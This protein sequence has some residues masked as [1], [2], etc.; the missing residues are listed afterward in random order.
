MAKTQNEIFDLIVEGLSS[1]FQLD[2]A[3]ITPEARLY[4]DLDID[5]IDAV[6][7][8]ARLQ[9]EIGMRLSPEVFKAVRT[10][11]DLVTALDGL[12]NHPVASAPAGGSESGP[13]QPIG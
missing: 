7:L 8:A 13:E 10:V 11:S 12:L 4:E 2:R 1:T 3:R 5:S 9:R 6:D